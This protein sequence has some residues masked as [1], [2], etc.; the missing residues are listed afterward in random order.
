ML[1]V[2]VVLFLLFIEHYTHNP[3][4]INLI[5]LTQYYTVLYPNMGYTTKPN[6]F[7]CHLYPLVPPLRSAL[8][9]AVPT[10]T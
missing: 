7:I 10:F 6:P 1:L 9:S 5:I 4:I 3:V 2:Y 8:A